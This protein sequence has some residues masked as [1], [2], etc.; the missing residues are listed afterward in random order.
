[1]CKD[2]QIFKILLGLVEFNKM[3]PQPLLKIKQVQYP[4]LYTKESSFGK[5]YINL[6]ECAAAVLVLISQISNISTVEKAD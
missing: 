1:M 4:Y 2:I 3:W 6:K 5:Y